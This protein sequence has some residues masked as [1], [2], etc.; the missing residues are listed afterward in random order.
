[1]KIAG[2]DVGVV[3]DVDDVVVVDDERGE[4][5]EFGVGVGGAVVVREGLGVGSAFG[6]FAAAARLLGVVMALLLHLCELGVEGGGVGGRALEA[7]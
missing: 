2:G 5:G 7:R 6:T 3:G 4:V 1:M